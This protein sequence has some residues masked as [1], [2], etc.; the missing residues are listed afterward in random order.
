V[1]SLLDFSCQRNHTEDRV[2]GERRQMHDLARHLQEVEEGERRRLAQ[3]LHDDLGQTITGLQ[4]DVAWLAQHLTGAPVASHRRLESMAQLLDVLHEAVHHIGTD[5]RPRILDDL[6]LKAAIVSQLQEAHQRTGIASELSWPSEELLLDK[7][8]ALALF[9]IFQ[10]ALR[11][12]L[13]HAKASSVV[14]RVY[15]QTDACYLEVS[16]NGRGIT[17][18]QLVDGISLGLLGMHERA[19]FWGGEVTIKGTPSEGTTVVVR[20]PYTGSEE[21][22]LVHDSDRD[23]R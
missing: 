3:A 4:L 6:G 1:A 12:V 18:A 5:L 17:P 8:R 20:L 13:R 11:N 15:Q 10:E 23:R 2:R 14:V 7:A 22:Q 9:R 19:L 16:D 21:A